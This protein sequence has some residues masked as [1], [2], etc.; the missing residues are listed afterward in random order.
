LTFRAVLRA[1]ATHTLRE[2]L[3]TVVAITALT[4]ADLIYM[5]VY[6]A[7]VALACVFIVFSEPCSNFIKRA[8]MVVCIEQR[9]QELS[10]FIYISTMSIDF[11][12]S[13]YVAKAYCVIPLANVW[14]SNVVVMSGGR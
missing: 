13:P 14:V 12:S 9:H 5:T 10:Q 7:V 6:S 2:T 3:A 11:E 8:V 1:S 4:M